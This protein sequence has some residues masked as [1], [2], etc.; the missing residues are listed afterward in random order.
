VERLVAD[1]QR[2]VSEQ[3]LVIEQLAAAGKP[4]GEA[5]L[6]LAT[7]EFALKQNLRQR[8][9]LRRR[10]SESPAVVTAPSPTATLAPES[11]AAQNSKRRGDG[12]KR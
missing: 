6:L 4:T 10:R 12:A 7:Y 3:T 5:Q 2:Y 11:M 8:D 9:Q 1:S